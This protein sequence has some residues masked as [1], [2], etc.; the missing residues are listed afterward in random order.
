MARSV[1][2]MAPARL[3]RVPKRRLDGLDDQVIGHP[4]RECE[5]HDPAR[6][7]GHVHG[8][9]VLSRAVAGLEEVLAERRPPCDPY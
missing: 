5:A 7:N 4:V 1:W 9:G 2:P 8:R 3:P 6:A